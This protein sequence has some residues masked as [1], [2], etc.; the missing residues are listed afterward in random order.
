VRRVPP[1]NYIFLYLR[2][3]SLEPV[4]RLLCHFGISELIWV[5][6][7]IGLQVGMLEKFNFC[8]FPS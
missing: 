8:K 7:G 2:K 5:F 3:Q 1:S 6:I 4:K